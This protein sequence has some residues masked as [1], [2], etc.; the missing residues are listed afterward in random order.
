M[1]KTQ[2]RTTTKPRSRG[3]VRPPEQPAPEP[4]RRDDPWPLIDELLP[5]L[6]WVW[7]AAMAVVAIVAIALVRML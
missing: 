1:E 2:L 6:A 7:L 3:A 4:K 5:R